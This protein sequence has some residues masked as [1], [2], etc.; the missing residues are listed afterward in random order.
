MHERISNKSYIIKEK[1][2]ISRTLLVPLNTTYANLHQ[3]IQIAFNLENVEY[4]EFET[5]TAL[6][7]RLKDG[8]HTC[9]SSKKI[10]FSENESFEY[11]YDLIHPLYFQCAVEKIEKSQRQVPCVIEATGKNLYETIIDKIDAKKQSD[12]DMTWTNQ[13]YLV[14]DKNN[15]I[16]QQIEASLLQ[17]M[18]E[19]TGIKYFQDYMHGQVVRVECPQ[20]RYV[21]FGCDASKDCYL[22][23]HRNGSKLVQYLQMNPQ[24]LPASIE[25]YQDCITLSLY[26]ISTAEKNNY[27]YTANGYGAF[28]TNY[29]VMECE[30]IRLDEKLLYAYALKQYVK[31]IQACAKN[32]MKLEDGVMRCISLQSTISSEALL[33]EDEKVILGFEDKLTSHFACCTR[34]QDCCEIDVLTLENANQEELFSNVLIIARNNLVDE[35]VLQNTSL[36]TIMSEVFLN[37]EAHFF[38]SGIV[39]QCIVRDKNMAQMMASFTQ[40]LQIDVSI[41]S[42]LPMIDAFYQ[43]HYA[44]M[45][46][47]EEEKEVMVQLFHAMG[48][49]PQI[50][51]KIVL[52]KGMSFE[53]GMKEIM[54]QL[55]IKRINYKKLN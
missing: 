30:N 41:Q 12:F 29:D 9:A 7:K 27:S 11:R 42:H 39:S 53:E 13:R 1:K 14:F 24:A 45:E 46:E 43:E 19:L 25:R 4:Y 22:N 5:N 35:I 40:A 6:I 26:K 21:Y 51:K 3:M 38:Q 31:V 52:P 16:H 15:K 20:K 37:L 48:I 34:S 17:S 55:M 18:K 54:A 50:I 47:G 10:H 8:K 49:E 44:T 2:K 23:F 36:K 32:Q 33:L 28:I